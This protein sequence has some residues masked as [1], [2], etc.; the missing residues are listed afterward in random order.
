MTGSFLANS[1]FERR[2]IKKKNK[3]H[4]YRD[5]LMHV[6]EMS[7]YVKRK[8]QNCLLNDDDEEKTIQNMLHKNGNHITQQHLFAIAKL[9]KW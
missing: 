1:I 8:T 4:T 5:L 7:V 6:C 2:N 3:I 9:L